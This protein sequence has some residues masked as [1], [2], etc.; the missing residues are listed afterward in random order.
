MSDLLDIRYAA[1]SPYLKLAAVEFGGLAKRA[2]LDKDASDIQCH[3]ATEHFASRVAA[4]AM[5]G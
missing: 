4:A 3:T 2:L 1:N 5:A